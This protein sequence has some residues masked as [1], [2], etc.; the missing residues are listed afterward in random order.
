METID[1]YKE[2]SLHLPPYWRLM[3]QC[4]ECYR[5]HWD[6]MHKIHNKGA[7]LGYTKGFDDVIEEGRQ[8]NYKES[9]TLI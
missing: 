9:T 8:N 1:E 6:I 3:K 4:S 2:H 7:T 5:E